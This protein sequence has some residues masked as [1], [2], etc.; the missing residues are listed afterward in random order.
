MRNHGAYR[1]SGSVADL[2]GG[3]AKRR[4]R[5]CAEC[6]QLIVSPRAKFCKPCV[7]G[8]SLDQNRVAEAKHRAY[9]RAESKSKSK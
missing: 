2:V 6:G 7:A 5:P 9:L 8:R 1:P 4:E 3:R